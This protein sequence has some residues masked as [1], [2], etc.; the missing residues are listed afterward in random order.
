MAAYDKFHMDFFLYISAFLSY[1][2]MVLH[3]SVRFDFH[4]RHT[5]I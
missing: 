2:L 5:Q 1:Q 4:H 3:N